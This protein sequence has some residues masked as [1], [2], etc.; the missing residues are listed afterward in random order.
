MALSTL[1]I[2]RYMEPFKYK[3]IFRGVFASDS[4]PHKVNLPSAFIINTSPRRQLE[5]HWVGLY[6]N[7]NGVAEYF[8]SFGFPPQQRDILNFIKHHSRKL[9]YNK[10]QIQH[11]SSNKCGK[12]AI[13]FILIKLF[14][15]SVLEL[16]DR[17]S[18]NLMVNDLILERIFSHLNKLG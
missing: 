3:K 16:V 12:F 14:K 8:D 11:L 7:R 13:V 10:K 17:F 2:V 6:L 9:I 5:G 18:L 15:R 1:D 4:L